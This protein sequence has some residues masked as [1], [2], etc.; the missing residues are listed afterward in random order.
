MAFDA[1]VYADASL[2]GMWAGLGRH[3]KAAGFFGVGGTVIAIAALV[4]GSLWHS[5]SGPV[6]PG[7]DVWVTVW[8]LMFQ[9]ALAML[10]MA[11]VVAA[12]LWLRQ[13]GIEL[14]FDPPADADR[15]L[16]PVRFSLRQLFLLMVV[17]GV[18]LQLGPVARTYLNDYRSYLS[19]VVAVT[20]GSV[21]LGS[22][23]LAALWAVFGGGPSAGRIAVACLIAAVLGL[24]PPYYFPELLSDNFLAS[25]SITVMEGLIVISTLAII[26]SCGYRLLSS[27]QRRSR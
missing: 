5:I 14:R 6:G 16:P 25:I 21:C 19:S 17:T 24:F 26:R 23:G 1:L 10:S 15:D 9:L 2:V 27:P 20:A 7:N 13:R 8:L 4:L 22:V 11:V 3:S 12:I 18:L